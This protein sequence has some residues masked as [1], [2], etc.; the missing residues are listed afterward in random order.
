MLRWPNLDQTM[1]LKVNLV[2]DQTMR[3]KVDPDLTA[4]LQLHPTA[5]ANP[6]SPNDPKFNSIEFA[7]EHYNRHAKKVL[8]NFSKASFLDI[9]LTKF[10]SMEHLTKYGWPLYLFLLSRHSFSYRWH[11]SVELDTPAL[12]S[13]P[14]GDSLVTTPILAQAT[15]LREPALIVA[16]SAMIIPMLPATTTLGSPIAT[17]NTGHTPMLITTTVTPW[18]MALSLARGPVAGIFPRTHMNPN[19]EMTNRSWAT[20]TTAQL[21][22]CRKAMAHARTPKALRASLRLTKIWS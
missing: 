10:E 11:A 12:L 16:S 5:I 4:S 2:L 13:V 1:H 20:R 6:P 22:E 17:G 14:E 8:W 3:L 7:K 15:V 19:L 9:H 21:V 18:V